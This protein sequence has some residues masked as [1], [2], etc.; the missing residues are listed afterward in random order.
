MEKNKSKNVTTTIIIILLVL[1]LSVAT[2]IAY[3]LITD[4]NK[5]SNNN[6]QENNE[7]KKENT[8]GK[9]SFEDCK[10]G[11]E[12]KCIQNIVLDGKETKLSVVKSDNNTW[13]IRVN[14]RKVQTENVD[15]ENEIDGRVYESTGKFLFK[16][17]CGVSGCDNYIVIDP[18]GAK[19]ITLDVDFYPTWAK[20]EEYEIIND[21][22][23]TFF[24]TRR[25]QQ[26][27]V[28]MINN[29]SYTCSNDIPGNTLINVEYKIKYLG[30]NNYNVERISGT[31]EYFSELTD[32][33][34]YCN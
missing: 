21:S 9:I 29:I 28:V 13:E 6:Q 32:F 8:V 12:E 4:E 24:A 19:E 15:F 30:N 23:I 18:T 7:T 20:K 2:V 34:S 11:T 16:L 3:M 17:S 27:E 26:A 33:K 5:N 31:E 22:E 25:G 10:N 1:I 14:D